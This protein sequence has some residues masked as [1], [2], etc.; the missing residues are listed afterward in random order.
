VYSPG[1]RWLAAVGVAEMF[2]AR[3]WDLT[4]PVSSEPLQVPI[5]GIFTGSWGFDPSDGWLATSGIEL[6]PVGAAYRRSVGRQDWFMDDVAFTPDGAKGR[7]GRFAR[8]PSRPAS[9]ER[10]V[11]CC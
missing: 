9:P 2:Y 8:G 3:L 4:A 10:D 1:G 7:T 11:S 6:R 5:V